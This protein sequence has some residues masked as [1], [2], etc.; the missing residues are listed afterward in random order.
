MITLFVGDNDQTLPERALAHDPGAWLVDHS[1]W[2][3]VLDHAGDQ[4]ITVYT[5][6][7]DLPKITQDRSVFWL[8]LERADEIYYVPPARWSDHIGR[9]TW[10]GQKTLTEFYLCLQIRSGGVVRGFDLALQTDHHYLDLADQRGQASHVI[11]I[12]GCS[13]SHGDG[14]L[15][16]Q[17]Y[18]HLIARETGRPVRWLTRS[19]SSLEWQADQ[20]LRSDLQ[21]GDTVIWGLTS[22]NRSPMAHDGWVVPWPDHS[23]E[24]L[25]YRLHETRYYK[26]ITSVFQVINSCEKIGCELILLPLMASEKLQI[27]LMRERTFHCLPYH[28]RY[29][30]LGTDGVHAGPLQHRCWADSCLEILHG[31][32]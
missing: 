1:N 21:P 31:G 27:A 7:S 20:I 26:A 28:T 11:W 8:L 18:G 25:H 29:L 32:R 12:V 9:F 14:V 15:P 30:D 4:S 24:D 3:Q 16:D 6:L 2:Q 10:S 22:E 13:L 19:G 5:S 23:M 17:R